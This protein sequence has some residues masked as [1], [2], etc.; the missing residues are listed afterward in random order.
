MI[1]GVKSVNARTAVLRAP[2]QASGAVQA[3]RGRTMGKIVCEDIPEKKP[4]KKARAATLRCGTT[5]F[6]SIHR[7]CGPLYLAPTAYWQCRDRHADG[8]VIFFKD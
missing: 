2:L 4:A 5:R 7:R 3:R 8:R 6:S 1:L